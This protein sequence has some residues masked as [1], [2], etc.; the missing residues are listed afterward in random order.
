M[1]RLQR[2]KFLFF[3]QWHFSGVWR[4]VLHVQWSIFALHEVINRKDFG[5]LRVTIRRIILNKFQFKIKKLYI[6]SRTFR[7]HLTFIFQSVDAIKCYD[8]ALLTPFKNYRQ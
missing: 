3:K 5:G 1:N 8:S 2:D 4:I 7:S 6:K